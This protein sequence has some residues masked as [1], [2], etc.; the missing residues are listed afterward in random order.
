M[1]P[2]LAEHAT[3][4]QKSPPTNGPDQVPPAVPEA[5]RPP[6]LPVVAATKFPPL[7]EEA[8][9]TQGSGSDL[10]KPQVTPKF[11]EV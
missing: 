8:Q 10:T 5:Y 4:V 2:P 6:L 1:F 3:P 7:A 11:T 9:A